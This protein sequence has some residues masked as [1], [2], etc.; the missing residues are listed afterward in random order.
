M[1]L[2]NCEQNNFKFI[3]ETLNYYGLTVDSAKGDGKT[4]CVVKFNF[5][6][7]SIA[8]IYTQLNAFFSG[9][10]DRI[11]ARIF[12]TELE[13]SNNAARILFYYDKDFLYCRITPTRRPKQDPLSAINRQDPYTKQFFSVI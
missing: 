5:E 13:A 9:Y 8:R 3:T 4:F 11:E 1:F 6:P 10:Y 2:N 12:P 7:R